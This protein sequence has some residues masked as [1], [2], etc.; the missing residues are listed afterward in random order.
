MVLKPGENVGPYQIIEQLGQGGMATVYKAYHANLDRYIA[1]KVLH[2]AF[3]EDPN[4]EK[5]FQR[6]A[7]VV[8]NLE[9]PNIVPVYDFDEHE[10]S[11]YLVMRFVEGETLKARMRAGAIPPDEAVDMISKIG[12]GLTYA[13][14]QG[15]L[16]RDIKPSNV[17][18]TED[19][20]IYLADFG[21]A[22]IAQSGE[23]TLSQD[24]MLGTP[25]YMSPEQARGDR[26]LD[27]RTDIY[28]LGV[29][30][31]EMVVGRVPF[32]ADTPY[33]VIHDH[34]FTPLP[35]PSS[36]NPN[37]P[38][39]VERVLL[40]ALAK[41]R[42]DRHAS[43]K[44]LADAFKEAVSTV[45]SQAMAASMGHTMPVDPGM[46]APPPPPPP[47]PH[48]VSTAH[49]SPTAEMATPPKRR[50]WLWGLVGLAA[51]AGVGLLLLAVVLPA[52]LGPDEEFEEGDVAEAEFEPGPEGESEAPPP[53]EEPPP[54]GG[55]GPPPP[56]GHCVEEGIMF[57][58]IEIAESRVTEYPDNA[59]A[60]FE[61]ALAFAEAGMGPPAGE[62]LQVALE[63]GLSGETLLFIGERFLEEEN[64]IEA[65]K[66]FSAAGEAGNPEAQQAAFWALL[67]AAHTPEGREL[68]H[69]FAENQPHLAFPKAVLALAYLDEGNFGAAEELAIGA[70]E[71]QPE[72]A[73]AHFVMGEFFLR[74]DLVPQAR[75]QYRCVTQLEGPPELHEEARGILQEL[76]QP[77]PGEE[78][79]IEPGQEPPVELL[80]CMPDQ[81]RGGDRQPG[82]PPE[83]PPT[84]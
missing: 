61:L 63:L 78:L 64:Y 58:P 56:E 57:L 4:F 71:T 3:K 43:A 46:V 39:P 13:H 42:D 14:E 28:S 73:I 7:K 23:S 77:E 38:E 21:L 67:D 50:L 12:D 62:Q 48:A 32:S 31:Y 2:A 49:P 5:R 76:G 40:K 36:V 37:V 34:I 53:P 47:P 6:E 83:Q 9:H 74:Q 8:A 20:K 19:N 54:P 24:M 35:I 81:P 16:H 82:Q 55:D 84:Q 17:I 22:R 29:V 66:F 70:I 65:A 11:P 27:A 69:A 18:L 44:A 1:I 33:A 80:G 45:G 79:R 60:H 15:V 41:E 51:L 26:D 75:A 30:L 59:C 68:I 72:S 25:A 52:L 10:G